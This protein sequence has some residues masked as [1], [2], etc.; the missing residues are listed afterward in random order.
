M[1]RHPTARRVHRTTSEDDAFVTGVLETTAWAKT[2]GT[3]LLVGV[4]AFVLVVAGLLWYRNYSRALEE[5]AASELGTVRATVQSGNYALARQDLEQFIGRFGGT[6]AADEAR[7]MLGQ[8]YLETSEPQQAIST[9]QPIANPGKPLGVNA[10]FLLATA[11]EAA[12]QPTEAERTY[13]E[14]ADKARFDYQKQDALD[15]AARL[16]LEQGNTAGAIELY[17]RIIGMFGE[18]PSP[19]KSLFQMRLAEIRASQQQ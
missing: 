2:H 8:V 17:E 16:R 9:L 12:N 11:Y 15:R 19:D 3:R 7:L 10:A 13:L 14:I 18:E 1:V 6:D 5:R 4:I